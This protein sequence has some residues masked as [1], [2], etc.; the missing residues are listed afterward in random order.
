MV[1]QAA[2]KLAAESRYSRVKSSLCRSGSPHLCEAL[3]G[4]YILPQS[5]GRI[6][7]KMDQKR[8][9]WT[10]ECSN[11]T[12]NGLDIRIHQKVNIH[13]P[14]RRSV[15]LDTHA[16]WKMHWLVDLLSHSWY[17]NWIYRGCIEDNNYA[18]A[19]YLKSTGQSSKIISYLGN[20]TVINTRFIGLT[21][22]CK[23][24]NKHENESGK[25]ITGRVACVVWIIN[26]DA[27]QCSNPCNQLRC[28][29]CI[30]LPSW[31]GRHN[32]KFWTI[33]VSE[34]ILDQTFSLKKIGPLKSQHLRILETI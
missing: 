31:S 5:V 15:C 6:C 21:V 26:K 9:R 16:I 14:G 30:M 29:H 25:E 12:R 4:P 17:Y 2:A 23:I 18:T 3:V 22:R 34:F 24:S 32:N 10:M 33:L 28:S 20:S 27:P 13:Q 11:S 7:H 19:W 8:N 1:S